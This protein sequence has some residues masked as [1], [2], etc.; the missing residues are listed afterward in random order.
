MEKGSGKGWRVTLVVLVYAGFEARTAAVCFR[1][2]VR[3]SLS[4]SLS[5]RVGSFSTLS[6]N[7]V[8]F[9]WHKQ[10]VTANSDDEIL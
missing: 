3:L 2:V 9:P 4:L 10:S 7:P 5:L 8:T 6:Y 1:D